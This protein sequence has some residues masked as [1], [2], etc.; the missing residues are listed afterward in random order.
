MRTFIIYSIA[1]VIGLAGAGAVQARELPDFTEL[2]EKQVTAVVNV[3]TKTIVKGRT[4]DEESM[5]EFFRRFGIPIDPDQ[6]RR[7]RGPRGEPQDEESSSLGSG[8]II[9]PDGYILTN[10]HVV[11]KADEITVKLTTQR[12]YKAKV[13][14]SDTRTDVALLKIDA[15]N[16]PVLT[17]GD[18][19]K[20]KV[21]EWV[22]AIG[23]PLGF[24]SSV[25]AGIVSGKTRKLGPANLAALIQTDVAIN[26]GNSGGPLFNM[27]GQVVGIN[28]MIISRSGGYM[29]LSFAIPIDVAMDV[30][31][32][33]KSG[34]KVS[35]GWI[36][37]GIQSVSKEVAESVGLPKPEGAQ[38]TQ[39]VKGSPADKAGFTGGE[40]VLKVD[41]K[42]VVQADDLSRIVGFMKPGQKVTLDVW[43]T[44]TTR[45][46][47]MVLGEL[48]SERRQGAPVRRIRADEAPAKSANKL[49]LAVSE[50]DSTKRQELGV[51]GGVLVDEAEGVAARAGLQR[52]DVIL[53]VNNA[54][55]QSPSD[56]NQA[57]A[58]LDPKKNAALLVRRG[59]NTVYVTLKPGNGN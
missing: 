13:I 1:A 23:S 24:E 34:G 21:G 2:A 48:P 32:Q 51:K 46:V 53:A 4:L 20:L 41:G 42:P 45:K 56:F 29:G 10:A 12:E 9:S 18:P 38:V 36:G 26:P 49:G 11:E 43:R 30:A 39:V 3:S 19:S 15:T 8:F 40:I 33:L 57:V 35:R 5:L 22:V 28:S 14:G 44:G 25:T 54:E 55:V 52:G 47:D 31:E 58:K 7:Y 17:F 50:L 37:V 16:L 59:E 6:L 27:D